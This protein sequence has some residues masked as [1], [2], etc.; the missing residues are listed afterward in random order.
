[1]P[2]SVLVFTTILPANGD[3]VTISGAVWDTGK[4]FR[5]GVGC[6]AEGGVQGTDRWIRSEVALERCAGFFVQN[7]IQ[8]G[9]SYD[10][11]C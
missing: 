1:L 5:G 9:T 7:L 6:L 4:N 3:W 8:S 2:V 10:Q 11:R